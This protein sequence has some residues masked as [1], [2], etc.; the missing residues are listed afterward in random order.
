MFAYFKMGRVIA[1][2]VET[3]TVF[4]CLPLFLEL[5]AFR[6]LSVFF[7]LVMVTFMCCQ[8]ISFGSRMIS[9]TFFGVLLLVKLECLI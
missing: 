1:L 5:N 3:I 8:N 7:A 4:F 2:N 6:I 9:R